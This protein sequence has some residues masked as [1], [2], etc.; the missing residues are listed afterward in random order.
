M[1]TY[2]STER[3]GIYMEQ[4]KRRHMGEQSE[5]IWLN[6]L[7]GGL[8]GIGVMFVSALLLPLIIVNTETPDSFVLPAALLCAILG[9]FVGG[10]ISAKKSKG[11]ELLSGIITAVTVLLPLILI[12]FLYKKGFS[13]IDFAIMV[14][15]IIASTL[16][17]SYLVAKSGT[18]KKHNMKK[19][20][21][22][23]R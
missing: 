8:I 9:G 22:K 13:L 15:A 4:A 6:S 23:P 11:A 5:N 12:S 21:K 14:V 18:N 2:I 1:L 19:L 17:A 7:T 3:M 20:M 16:I 10:F